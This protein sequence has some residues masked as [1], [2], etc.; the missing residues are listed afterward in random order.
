[1]K[2][3]SR[4][5]HRHRNDDW[6]WL[7]II[8]L[9]CF[10]VM[11][12]FPILGVPDGYDIAQ[13]LRFAATYQEAIS[14]GTLLPVWSSIENLGFGSVG[15][16][17]YPPL[18]DYVL[19]VTNV[20]IN[21]WYETLSLNSVAWMFPGCIGVY[22][23]VKEIRSPAQ[24]G[25]AAILYAIFPYHLLQVYLFQLYAE[26][27]ASAILPFCFLFLTRLLKRG[28]TA[29]TFGLAVACSLLILSHIPSSI[30]GFLSLALFGALLMD[31]K[32]PRLILRQI[33]LAMLVT[34]GA[35]AFYVV[36]LVTEV[37]WVTHNQ[38]RFS[39][40]FYDHGRHLFPLVYNFG[41]LYW[42]RLLWIL[43]LTIVFTFI[44]FI[45]LTFFVLRS[46]AIASR[47][48]FER[49]FLLGVAVTGLFSFFML[50][51]LS[52][53]IW[54]TFT[55]L[56]RT[57]FP[58]RFLSIGSLMAVVIIGVTIPTL[59]HQFRRYSRLFVYPIVILVLAISIF[60][61]T[62]IILMAGQLTREK[63]YELVV[64]KIP[65]EACSCWWPIWG[66]RKALEDPERAEV[67]NRKVVISS[68]K[69]ESRAFSV[70]DGAQGDLRI[71]TFYYPYWKATVNAHT[72]QIKTDESGAI[73]IPIGREAADVH[74]YFE[75]PTINKVALYISLATWLM[76]LLVASVWLVRKLFPLTFFAH[77]KFRAYI[78][79]LS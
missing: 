71:A 46:R 62:Q 26:F 14:D 52:G 50:T 74:L 77:P 38:D 4:I 61:L 19:A 22:F 32:N 64:D 20:F 68:W 27:V 41:D 57:Q 34:C 18:A 15:I 53:F 2:S 8:C 35:T 11:L 59:V 69:R 72:V 39:T 55:I 43:D 37:D 30:I 33:G 47:E 42:Q 56:Q 78:S 36:R 40:G 25:F 67:S 12:A 66:D 28:R 58:W 73:L 29:D 17:F 76:L 10:L 54:N 75:E 70:G 51:G 60:D 6:V 5:L 45:P 1:M 31:W 49:T 44:A 65:D 7:S 24:A 63:F 13:H 16:R 21:D 9:V 48:T 79:F 3:V 23:W